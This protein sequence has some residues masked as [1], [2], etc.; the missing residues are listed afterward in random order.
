MSKE[1]GKLKYSV[2]DYIKNN[3][4]MDKITNIED[5]DIEDGGSGAIYINLKKIIK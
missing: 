4:L 1:F 2:P 5:A 3:E